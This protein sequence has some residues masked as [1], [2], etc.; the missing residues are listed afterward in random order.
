M[1]KNV[2]IIK[3][4]KQI[5]VKE[6]KIYRKIFVNGKAFLLKATTDRDTDIIANNN[7]NTKKEFL[8]LI[9]F[10]LF[11]FCL[12][13]FHLMANFLFSY[14]YPL[15]I[16]KGRKTA[17]CL[18]LFGLFN[19]KGQPTIVVIARV[20]I[21]DTYIDG[22]FVLITSIFDKRLRLNVNIGLVARL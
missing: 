15:L 3:I 21:V 6:R 8:V 1:G 12:F 9:P 5:M 22:V 2:G 20:V 4:I 14:I 13:V 11:S 18:K 19:R 17:L 10:F 16:K 7:V